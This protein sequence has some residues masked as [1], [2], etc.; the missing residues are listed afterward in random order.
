MHINHD[1]TQTRHVPTRMKL[2]LAIPIV[3]LVC[4]LL[5]LIFA[6]SSDGLQT[7]STR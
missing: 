2:I 3:I 1:P 6:G 4:H 5:L 7:P